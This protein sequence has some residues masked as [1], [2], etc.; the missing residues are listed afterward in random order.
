MC[1]WV[2]LLSL[3]A[4]IGLFAEIDHSQS[5]SHPTLQMIRSLLYLRK[6]FLLQNGKENKF[7]RIDLRLT[8]SQG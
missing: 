1:L 2:R 7:T 6:S 8:K 5:S 4:I 3:L